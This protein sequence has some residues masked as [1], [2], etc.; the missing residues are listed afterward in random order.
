MCLI[1]RFPGKRG[2]VDARKIRMNFNASLF[3][4]MMDSVVDVQSIRRS[5]P[6]LCA[7]I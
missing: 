7:T 1:T 3:V 5:L 2:A 6:V 4:Y